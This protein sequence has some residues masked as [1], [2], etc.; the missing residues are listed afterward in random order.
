MSRFS[1]SMKITP[2]GSN[3][4]KKEKNCKDVG[5]FYELQSI[6]WTD[7]FTV[8]EK[9][10]KD[11]K[12]AKGQYG[13]K[14]DE[15][16]DSSSEE[17]DDEAVLA[18]LNV[19]AQIQAALHAIKS[20]DPRRLD[21]TVTFYD[22]IDEDT[23]EG[24]VE[25]KEKPMYL[26]D[27]HRENLLK[28][29]VDD[30]LG[31]PA[32]KTYTQE[33]D[34]LKRE[35]VKQMHEVAG[36]G[37]SEENDE[38]DFL[39]S[40]TKPQAETQVHPSRLARAKVDPTT[41]DK[42]PE[43]YL[44]NFMEAR[45][46]LPGDGTRFQPL[47]SDDEDEDARADA[48]EVAYNLRF[49]DPKGSNEVLKSYARDVTAAKSVRRDEKSGRKKQ[50]DLQRERKEAEKLERDQERAR[51]RKLKIDEL[52]G[53]IQKVKKAA[54]MR[55][56]TLT[57]DE[58][59]KL[60]DGD[61]DVK[62]WED[63]TN[64]KFGEEYY[65]EKELGDVGSDAEVSGEVKKKAKKPKWDDD[66]DIKDLVSDF[67]DEEDSEKAGFVLSDSE[68]E[69]DGGATIVK[70]KSSKD[71]KQEKADKK[72]AARLERRK[73]EEL[74]DNQMDLDV[75]LPSKSSKQP[76][77]FKY[78]ET[79]PT[80]FGLTAMDILMAPDASLNQFAGLKKM[81][82]FRD[83]E[84]KRK[85]K[86]NLSKKARLRQWRKETFGNEEGPALVEN[87]ADA[88]GGDKKKKKKRSKK[89]KAGVEEEV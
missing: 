31:S 88:D 57:E 18:T 35:L 56:T 70:P 50:R 5:S 37:D 17:E 61:W 30:D 77:R 62:Q 21:E 25:K 3:T 27:Y 40:K 9:Y 48:F 13:D 59:A 66:I 49:E 51:L 26:T 69:A 73:I 7:K 63:E 58:L 34:D 81:A 82:S 4:T 43:N 19:D 71:R 75:D 11:S 39:I 76:T 54:G 2:D 36:S 38:E 55:K 60:L 86:K 47:D 45:A 23:V 67:E 72:K 10:K 32:V 79:S 15:D 12:H 84:K 53:K 68:D 14:Y 46:W 42:D 74:V 29:N 80:S 6:S 52:E 64:K 44:S 16:S 33:Q 22:P 85:D 78:R 8:E 87:Q 41:A 89:S 1:R 20:R 83:P 24:V 28:G 65:A